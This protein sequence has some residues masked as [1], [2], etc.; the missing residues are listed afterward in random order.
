MTNC[1]LIIPLFEY[2]DTNEKNFMFNYIPAA[3]LE[4]F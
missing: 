1:H 2:L 4:Q 3:E